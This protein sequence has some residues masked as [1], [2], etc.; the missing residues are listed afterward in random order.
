MGMNN[1]IKLPLV[2]LLMVIS[3]S[4]CEGALLPNANI[5]ISN[6]SYETLSRDDIIPLSTVSKILPEIT[7]EISTGINL[8]AVGKPIATRSVVYANA[9]GAKKVTISVDQ[10][11]STKDAL[12]AY[13]QA[14]Q[15][16]KLPGFTTLS[17]PNLGQQSFAG[18]ITKN[19]ETHVGVGVL[20]DDLIIG[21]TLAG[22][23]ASSNNLTH[24]VKLIHYELLIFNDRIR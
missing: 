8:T 12:L 17:M 20:K 14:I 6:S 9:D 4:E 1:R 15:K 19:G 21:V 11:S 22:Y 2:G 13:Q 23:K 18:T 7:R 16:S 3:S 10:Y 24:I 5:N